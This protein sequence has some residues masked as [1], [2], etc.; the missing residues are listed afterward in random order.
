[1]ILFRII[2]VITA[3]FI[4]L[5]TSDTIMSFPFPTIN[6]ANV[7]KVHNKTV[8]PT[9]LNQR[10]PLKLGGFNFVSKSYSDSIRKAVRTN[11]YLKYLK[12]KYFTSSVG[13]SIC[14][15][16]FALLEKF[17]SSTV[18]FQQ[19]FSFVSNAMPPSQHC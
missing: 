1:M 8:F 15:F 6:N 18:I 10:P 12:T 17:L 19:Q 2:N 7:L 14:E 3:S 4:N 9:S 13:N 11:S 5:R 16:N